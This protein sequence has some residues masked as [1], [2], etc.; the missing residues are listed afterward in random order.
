MKFPVAILFSFFT[1]SNGFVPAPFTQQSR[2]S[3]HRSN[4]NSNASPQSS[5]HTSFNN[6]NIE[7]ALFSSTEAD[8]STTTAT[9]DNN[10]QFPPILT[11]LR[12]VAMKLHTREQA[13]KEGQAAAPS[14]PKEPYVPTQAD[15]LQF[16]VDSHEV[17]MALE[18][19]V[20]RPDLDAE[21]GRFRNNGIERTK[22]LE[23]DIDWMCTQFSL[24]KPAVGGAGS[25]YA[26]ELRNMVTMNDEGEN[27]G[28]PEFV[29]H[30]YNY[31]FAHLAGGR[32]IGKQ[33]SKMLLDGETLEFY[34]VSLKET[35]LV[36]IA[37]TLH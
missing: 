19:V 22:E 35:S 26:N 7:S 9:T 27:V 29:C 36:L 20:N 12:D 17:Y 2:V 3:I 8:S 13:P 34:K 37:C 16:L 18:E 31:Y 23:K 5:A 24:D 28:V 6:Y 10:E 33:M 14:K 1:T 15:Y 21:L 11:E 32:M 30:Y 4:N 25:R